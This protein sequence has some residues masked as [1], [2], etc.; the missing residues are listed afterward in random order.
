MNVNKNFRLCGGTFFILLLKANESCSVSQDIRFRDFLGVI[1]PVAVKDIEDG[2]VDKLHTYASNFR[3]CKVFP[4]KGKYIRLGNEKICSFF[5]DELRMDEKAGLNRVVEFC[6]KY[7][8]QMSR[9]WLVRA[10]LELIECDISIKDNAVF[11][12]KPGFQ[13]TYKSEL[14]SEAL[15]VNFY[16]FL[17]G[18]W[19]YVYENCPDNTVGEKTVKALQTDTKENVEGIFNINAI[20]AAETYQNI[21][22]DYEVSYSVREDDEY[23]EETSE[24]VYIG[25]DDIVP[26]LS[27]FNS[28]NDIILMSAQEANN[29]IKGKFAKY[30]GASYKKYS[31]KRTFLYDTERNFRKFYVCNDICKRYRTA[32]VNT[33]GGVE[34]IDAY[35]NPISN[36]S[37]RCFQG[38]KNIIIGQGGLGKTMMANHLFLQTIDEYEEEQSMPILTPL[39]DYIPKEK[40]LLFLISQSITRFDSKLQLS[41]IVS[42]LDEGH[43]VIL[44]DGLDEVKKEHLGEL[45]KEIE[46]MSDLYEDNFFIILTRNMQEIRLLNGF[47]EYYLLPLREAQV[48]EVIE[49]MDPLYVDEDLKK[50]FIRDIKNGRFRFSEKEK[51]EFLG[52][53]LFLTIM[54]TSYSQTNNIPTQR[55]LFYEQAYRAMATRHDALKGITRNFFTGLNEREF[56][57]VLGQFCAESYADYNLKFDRKL[58]DRYIQKVID[59]NGL[60]TDVEMFFKDIT[61]KLCLVY[62]EGN[63]YRFIHRSFQEYFAAYYF[64]TLMDDE[65]KDVYDV[66]ESLDGQIKSDDTLGM[67]CGLDERKF[68]R[69][70]VIPC[71]ERLF[72]DS[73]DTENYMNYL[74][75]FY[76]SLEYTTGDLDNEMAQ[77]EIKSA[78]YSFIME[79][80]GIL[81][82][83]SGDN[84]E[85]DEEWS[86]CFEQYYI[87]EDYR[88]DC[89]YGDYFIESETEL[90][91]YRDERGEISD[92]RISV[93]EAGYLCSI[94]ITE[95]LKNPE[96]DSRWD[97]LNADDF[98]TRVEFD[99]AYDL[100]TKLKEKYKDSNGTKKKRFGLGL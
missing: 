62:Q 19:Y 67:L 56:Q 26:D 49:K 57:K 4:P 74:R 10:L 32:V 63:E 100:L 93:R 59:D 53:P 27:R 29:M 98:P 77:N 84:F 66:L 83:I 13:P 68:E 25:A 96:Y 50:R 82:T 37:V 97:I 95:L 23:E 18:V 54:I 47:Q 5:K 43:N 6:N 30:M 79:H 55:Y 86:D 35:E 92:E 60:K 75:K 38:L 61:E 36:V 58:L 41:D 51:R 15:E 28:E 46:Y 78:L 88:Y 34:P 14:L 85:D 73:D 52:N 80:Y 24:F 39:S 87:V 48:Y 99:S 7:I 45:I 81:E 40:D 42:K 16:S 72:Y 94:N 17:L 89:E 2:I 91:K 44:L 9:P 21:K 8:P 20:G 69:F 33:W 11:Y 70:I 90:W 31:N 64:T 71:L 65:Y 3:N 76:P 1:D 22:I 12:A